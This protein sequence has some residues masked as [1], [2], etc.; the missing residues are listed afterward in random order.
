L[1]AAP[2]VL[3]S[4]STTGQRKRSIMR[5]FSLVTESVSP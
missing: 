1:V 3:P 2:L 4:S 5:W